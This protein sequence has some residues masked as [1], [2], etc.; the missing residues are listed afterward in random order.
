MLPV[1]FT[2]SIFPLNTPLRAVIVK[3]AQA[4]SLCLPHL[5][6]SSMM[7][8]LSFRFLQWISSAET[9]RPQIPQKAARSFG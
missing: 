7:S 2:L 5:A 3:T 9:A 1:L 6:Y 8:L 4:L